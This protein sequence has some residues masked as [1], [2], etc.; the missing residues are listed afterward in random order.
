MVAL[1]P[2]SPRWGGENNWKKK[3]NLVGQGKDSITEQQR[4]QTATTIILIKRIYKKKE[5]HRATLSPPD[6][7]WLPSRDSPPHSQLRHSAPSMMAHGIEYPIWPVWVSHPSCVPFWLVVES[8]PTPAEPRTA[9][10]L[11]FKA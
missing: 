9:R 11:W 1:S 8:D 4:K 7:Q 10:K 6:A 5:T 2:L 3:A